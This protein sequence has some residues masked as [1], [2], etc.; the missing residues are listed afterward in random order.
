MFPARHVFDISVPLGKEP[1][2]YPGDTPFSRKETGAANGRGGYRL[3]SLSLSAHAG[4][5]IDA[6]AH[7]IPGGRTIDA[8]AASEWIFPAHVV[9]IADRSSTQP[10]ALASLDIRPGDA[11]LFRTRS[12]DAGALRS[13][14]N[15]ALS[16]ETAE[17]C[18]ERR[19]RLVGIDQLSVDNP[20]DGTFPVHRLLLGAGILILE[21]IDLASVPAGAYTLV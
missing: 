12:Q 2:T 11:L 16:L 21:C 14:G 3:S 19:I 13:A 1:V 8:Y 15:I 10:A 17:F 18:A 9:E 7:F 5:H 20:N 6:P 4:T